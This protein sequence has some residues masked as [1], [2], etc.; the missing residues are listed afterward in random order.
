METPEQGV[1]YVQVNNKDTLSLLLLWTYFTP[2]Y[3]FIAN[4]KQV[5]A[6]WGSYAIFYLR[7]H[8]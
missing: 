3:V 1:K 5:N 4:I 7:G 2:C 8:P 6:G